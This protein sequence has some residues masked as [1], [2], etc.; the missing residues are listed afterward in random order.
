MILKYRKHPVCRRLLLAI[1]CNVMNENQF[2]LSFWAFSSWS[3]VPFDRLLLIPFVINGFNRFQKLRPDNTTVISKTQSNAF[4]QT[5]AGPGVDFG[6]RSGSTFDHIRL[7]TSYFTHLSSTITIR[8]KNGNLLNLSSRT[9]QVVFPFSFYLL[10]SSC[11][12]ISKP[13]K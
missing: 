2:M 4:F 9:S 11:G 10:F 3:T 6:I 12:P 8:C 13:F 1:P 7:R 5:R